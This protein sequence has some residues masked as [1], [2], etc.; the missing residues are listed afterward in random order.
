MATVTVHAGVCGFVTTI[1]ATSEDGQ[2]VAISYETTCPHAQKAKAEL[3]SVDAYVEIFKKPA[4]TTVY[5]V[6]SRHLVH[7]ACPLY[8]GFLK[9]IE[10]AAS[11][12]LPRDVTMKI[13]A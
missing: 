4:D 12:A 2:N 6:M 10:V 9:A 8:S 1:S 11:L 7:T 13:E 5:A 3:T